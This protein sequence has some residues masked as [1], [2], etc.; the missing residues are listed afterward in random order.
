MATRTRFGTQN[1]RC[2]K[3]TEVSTPEGAWL[4]R[5]VEWCDGRTSGPTG[6]PGLKIQRS[7]RQIMPASDPG[8]SPSEEG[9]VFDRNADTPKKPCGCKGKAGK[10]CTCPDW[11]K[12]GFMVGFTAVTWFI[13]WGIG[14]IVPSG[15]K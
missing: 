5:R 10:P 13:L 9:I 2:V 6:I 11:G 8:E 15:G 3:V 12:W 14:A 1:G 4:V 7:V